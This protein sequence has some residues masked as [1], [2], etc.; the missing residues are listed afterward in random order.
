MAQ[1]NPKALVTCASCA[2]GMLYADRFARRGYNVALLAGRAERPTALARMLR[3]ETAVEIEVL[4]GDLSKGRCL[5]RIEA[6]IFAEGFDVVVN[7]LAL[8]P[9]RALTEERSMDLDR[10]LGT[11]VRAYARISAAAVRS[12]ASRRKGAIINVT[13]AV[14]LAPEISGGVDGAARAFAMALTRTMQDEVSASGVYVQLVLTAATRTDVWPFPDPGPEIF[15]GMMTANDLVDAALVG[16]DRREPVTMPSLARS[17]HW[18]D[19]ENARTTLLAELVNSE[20]AHRYRRANGTNT[21]KRE[22]GSYFP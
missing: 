14:G 19:Y 7:N 8:P 20:P 2:I 18:M 15:P 11:N 17:R 21:S 1:P 10:L 4:P 5:D 13:S 9:G 3:A 16:F 12:M 6:R 22:E